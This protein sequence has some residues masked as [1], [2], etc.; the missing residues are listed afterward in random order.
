MT[1]KLHFISLTPLLFFAG[2][3]F[4]NAMDTGG[5]VFERSIVKKD[6]P[7]GHKILDA[8]RECGVCGGSGA[9]EVAW[10][11][12]R[13]EHAHAECLKLIY[14]AQAK[15]LASLNTM[16]FGLSR[17]DAHARAVNA[18]EIKIQ[19]LGYHSI[20]SYCEECGQ[21]GLKAL[22]DEQGEILAKN[23]H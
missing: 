16:D 2:S 14:A 1:R 13:S 7:F 8:H 18:V 15:F 20:K 4:I 12:Y 11:S 10:P 6:K 17:D 23:L 3:S 9:P 5:V 21:A 19:A 22:F